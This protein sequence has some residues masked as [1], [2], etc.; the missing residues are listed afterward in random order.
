MISN[1]D[2]GLIANT[3]NK[4]IFRSLS[5]NTAM[6]SQNNSIELNYAVKTTNW[7][8]RKFFLHY[9]ENPIY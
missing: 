5:Q 6:C 8:M 3:A 1:G 2:I 7:W 4:K 9:L